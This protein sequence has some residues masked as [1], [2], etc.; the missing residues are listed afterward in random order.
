MPS[1]GTVREG[2]SRSSELRFSESAWVLEKLSSDVV[3]RRPMGTVRGELGPDL[4]PK[5]GWFWDLYDTYR[6]A[7]AILKRSR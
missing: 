2:G 3:N 4:E 6:F 5:N 7:E 1:A